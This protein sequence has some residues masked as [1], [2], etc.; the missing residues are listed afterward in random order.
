LDSIVASSSASTITFL[1]GDNPDNLRVFKFFNNGG[2]RVLAS[3]MEWDLPGNCLHQAADSDLLFLV[4]Q[5]ENGI[6][7]STVTLV[8]DVEGTAFNESGIAYEYRL[9]LFTKTPTTSYDAANDVTKVY[10]KADTYDSN[11]EAVVVVDDSAVERGSVYAGLQA[12]NDGAWY[13]T[14][15]GDRT[16]ATNVVL[17]YAY[18]FQL[19]LPVFY[20][21]QQMQNGQFQSD[22]SNIPRVT[23]MVIQSNDTGPYNAT[24]HLL[25]RTTKEYRFSQKTANA[26][27]ANSAPLP[28]IIDNVIPI[29]G[30]GTDARVT[31]HSKTPF[32][33]SLV[34]AT[35]YGIYSNRGIQAV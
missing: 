20:R 8:S 35:W 27:L 28:A 9:D 15:P 26:Y 23:R 4:T 13:V 24:V 6:C 34:A 17:G 21:K 33:L 29:Y 32:P 14:V 12:A 1:A 22:V 2:E 19:V 30:K 7:L 16:G 18:E 25:G 5:Q 10:F 31:L 3:W 11:R